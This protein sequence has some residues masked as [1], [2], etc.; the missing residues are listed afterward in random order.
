MFF[1][2]NQSW[3]RPAPDVVGDELLLTRVKARDK[4]LV[5]RLHPLLFNPATEAESRPSCCP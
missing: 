5:V 1:I 2:S 4:L 3:L